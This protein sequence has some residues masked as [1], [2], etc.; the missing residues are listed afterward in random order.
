MPI[1]RAATAPKKTADCTS[2]ACKTLPCTLCFLPVAVNQHAFRHLSEIVLGRKK[3]KRGEY[4]YQPAT[5]FRSLYV[6]RT[7]CFKTFSLGKNGEE[8]VTGFHMAGELLGLDAI[9]G[10]I[11]AFYAEALEDSEVCELPYAEVERLCLTVPSFQHELHKIMSHEIVSDRGRMILL[12]N[13]SADERLANFLLNLSHRFEVRG[14][15]PFQFHLRMTREEIGSYLGLTL[16]TVSRTLSRF[17]GEGLIGVQNKL[18]E[19]K[20]MG[21]LRTAANQARI[22]S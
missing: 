9:A 2:R 17:Q 19:L 12:S 20:D 18:V 6:L 22:A 11:H 5:P 7:G 13:K 3:L 10:D 21:A 16:E 8:Y 4:L 14:Y 1:A 15:S